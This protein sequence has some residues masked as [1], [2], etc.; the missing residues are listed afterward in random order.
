MKHII[1]TIDYEGKWGM[2][3]ISNYNLVRTTKSLLGVLKKYNVKAVFFVVG[4]IIEE[5]PLLIKEIAKEDHEISIHGYSHEH[6]DKLS[7]KDLAKLSDKLHKIEISLKKLTGKRPLGFRSPFLMAPKFYTPELYKLLETHGY[8]WTSNRELR[9]AEEI[10]RPDRINLPF[11][12]G[13]NN[14]FIHILDLIVNLKTLI[15]VLNLLKLA[16]A[17]IQPELM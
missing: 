14:S 6:Y 3:Y 10:F 7:E 8:K 11:L 9:F 4:K 13:K 1:L 17:S 12:W 16:W 5:Y 15:Y 2:P